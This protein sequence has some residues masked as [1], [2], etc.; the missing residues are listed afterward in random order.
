MRQLV[1]VYFCL[2]FFGLGFS[3]KTL[4][5]GPTAGVTLAPAQV[6]P[7]DD[8]SAKVYFL[9]PKDGATV[10]RK[11]KAKFGVRNLKIAMAGQDVDNKTSG[12]HHL[13]IDQGAIAEGTVIPT[14]AQHLHYG[15]GQ[16]EAEVE[17]TPGVHTLTLQFAD[18]AHRSYGK[19]RS[20]TIKV[21]VK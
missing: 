15:K 13:L 4:A 17:L 3:V 21:T 14:D 2:A 8:K 12:H 9:E 10:P 20:Q 16:A 7:V 1:Y 11:F 19:E 5:A 6:L 18:G